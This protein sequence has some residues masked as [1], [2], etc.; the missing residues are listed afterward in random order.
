MHCV[1]ALAVQRQSAGCNAAPCRSAAICHDSVMHV[2]RAGKSSHN[3]HLITCP[4]QFSSTLQPSL[5]NLTKKTRTGAAS[6]RRVP[7]NWPHGSVCRGRTPRPPQMCMMSFCHMGLCMCS[8]VQPRRAKCIA[9]LERVM[10]ASA[11]SNASDG[12]KIDAPAA[13]TNE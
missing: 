6:P 8:C 9:F 4:V 10:L 12:P 3:A 7:Q 1:D 5:L 11:R 13:N 2:K